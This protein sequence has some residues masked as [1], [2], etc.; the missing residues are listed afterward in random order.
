MPA[1]IVPSRR[2]PLSLLQILTQNGAPPADI[3]V[4]NQNSAGQGRFFG[5]DPQSLA[6]LTD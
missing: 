3:L 5:C 4:R 6:R 2:S 1:G